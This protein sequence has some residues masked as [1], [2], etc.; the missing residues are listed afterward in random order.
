MP[1]FLS[2]EAAELVEALMCA[3][4]GTSNAYPV[5][6]DA[7]IRIAIRFDEEK[8]VPIDTPFTKLEA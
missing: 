5:A 2:R 4:T 8:L 3:W 1:R 7:A 6:L